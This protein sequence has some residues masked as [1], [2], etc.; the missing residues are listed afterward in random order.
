MYNDSRFDIV[1]APVQKPLELWQE[2]L[3]RGAQYLR[4]HGWARGRTK[5]RQTGQ[6]CLA[7]A[8]MHSADNL[9]S[10]IVEW[11][12]LSPRLEA[13]LGI[14]PVNWNYVDAKSGEEVIAFLEKAAGSQ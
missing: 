11:K 12:E 10:G 1:E 2:Q 6:V 14:N 8:I 9:H 5:D 13:L 3:L 7:G 4:I